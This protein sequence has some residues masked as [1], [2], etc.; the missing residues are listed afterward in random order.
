MSDAVVEGP[1]Y[2]LEFAFEA[3]L[4]R[5]RIVGGEDTGLGVSS[6]YWLRIAD[7]VRER[8]AGQLLVLDAMQGEVMSPE[9]LERFFDIISGRGLEQVRLAYVEGRADQVSRVEYAE[10]LAR[11]RGYEIRM[12]GNETDAL[13][14]LRYGLR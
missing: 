12:F 11:E 10:L 9:D 6:S 13:V 5:V 3:P 8:G 2:R 14:W 4:L 1:G 7:E